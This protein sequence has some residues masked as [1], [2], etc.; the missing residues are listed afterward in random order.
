M[1]GKVLILGAQGRFGR[2]AAEAFWN[3]GWQVVLFDRAT[4]DLAVAATGVDVIVN[5]WNPPYNAWQADVP[6][7]T[8]AVIAAAKVH[9][10]TV[11]IPGN[12]YGYGAGSPEVLASD[13][14]KVARNP[15]GRIR[16]DMEAAY[17]ASGVRTIVLRAGN[18]IDTQPSGNWF[19]QVIVARLPKGQMVSPGNPDAPQAWAYLPDLAKAAVQLASRR[20]NLEPFQEVLFPGHT[21][22]LRDMASVLETV[23]GRKFRLKR[24]NWLPI[25]LARPFWSLAKGIL[26][27]RYL[28]SMPHQLDGADMNALLPEFKATDPLTAWARAIGHLDIHPDQTVTGGALDIAAE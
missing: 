17:R 14:P 3:A 6:A 27:M 12:I 5:G 2:N 4:D 10:A 21:L 23:T 15:L 26:E 24:M 28:W 25:Y 11:I 16:N 1:S 22:S 18:F 8:K 7:M 20:A 9:G 19:D 13:T